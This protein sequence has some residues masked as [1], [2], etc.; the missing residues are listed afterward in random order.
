MDMYVHGNGTDIVTIHSRHT[1]WFLALAFGIPGKTF[2]FLDRL[3]YAHYM[4]VHGK[5]VQLE[6]NRS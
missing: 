6:E 5:H 3:K 1:M 2:L 4:T